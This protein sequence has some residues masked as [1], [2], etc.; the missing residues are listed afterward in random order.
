VENTANEVVDVKEL[1][2]LSKRIILFDFGL[3]YL[4]SSAALRETKNL[5]YSFESGL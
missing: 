5:S 4:K 2:S 1:V 3:P